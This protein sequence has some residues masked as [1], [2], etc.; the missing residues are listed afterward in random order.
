MKIYTLFFISILFNFSVSGQ[1]EIEKA[2]ILESE[3]GIYLTHEQI[4]DIKDQALRRT[5]TFSKYFC[6]TE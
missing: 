3:S 5:R 1:T 6:Y 4:A 2:P